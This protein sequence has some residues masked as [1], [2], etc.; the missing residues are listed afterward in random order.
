MPT[1]SEEEDGEGP[2]ASDQE[3]DDNAENDSL[4]PNQRWGWSSFEICT[5]LRVHVI[6][7]A[8]DICTLPILHPVSVT[9]AH[10]APYA[11]HTQTCRDLCTPVTHGSVDQRSLT[12]AYPLD[13][14]TGGDSQQL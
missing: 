2:E 12:I 11:A 7:A 4:R 6:A 14:K 1:G 8:V 9:L 13:I 3:F 5:S 10:C